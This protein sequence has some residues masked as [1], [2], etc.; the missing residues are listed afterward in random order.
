[1]HVTMNDSVP[2]GTSDQARCGFR[3]S[4][5]ATGPGSAGT[6]RAPRLGILPPSEIVSLTSRTGSSFVRRARDNSDVDISLVVL[7]SG[8]DGGAPQF[9]SHRAAAGTR[10]ASSIAVIIDRNSV[11]LFDATPDLRQQYRALENLLDPRDARSPV[12]A[13]FVTHAHMGH[14]GGLMHFGKEATATHMTPLHA[15]ASV[16][17]FLDA[18]EPWATLLRSE[19]LVGHATDDS[20]VSYGPITVHAIPVPHRADFSTTVAYSIHVEGR[21]WVL[22]LPDIDGWDRWPEAVDVIGAHPINLLDA[23]FGDAGEVPGRPIEEIPHPIV[24]DTIERFAD[25]GAERR[26][27]L[28]HLNHT[29]QLGVIGSP[30][31]SESEA[32]GFEVAFDGMRIEYGEV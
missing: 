13:V 26:I 18:N 30:I 27:V 22:Y 25:L 17:E 2:G 3:L 29:N 5:R 19:H 14:Y 6:A 11:L 10:T 8:Q 1:M 28:T 21:P 12:D 4:L 20:D 32:A 15:P 24:T 31:R 16:L 9:G 23:T 7:G